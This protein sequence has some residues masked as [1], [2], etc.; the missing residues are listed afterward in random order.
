MLCSGRN[1]TNEG[2]RGADHV[3]QPVVVE[4]CAENDPVRGPPAEERPPWRPGSRN[5]WAGPGRAASS[6]GWVGKSH[7][8]L[9]APRRVAPDDDAVS[10]LCSTTS[11]ELFRKDH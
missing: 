8:C 1:R 2:G 3:G 7:H 4:H 11:L 5:S 9:P 10:R 6:S